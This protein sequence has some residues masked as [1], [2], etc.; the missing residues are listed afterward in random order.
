ML[1]GMDISSLFSFLHGPYFLFGKIRILEREVH[2]TLME[3]DLFLVD[4]NGMF[5]HNSH[6]KSQHIYIWVYVNLDHGCMKR[7][8]TRVTTI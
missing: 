2:G 5:L 7:I 4:K 1:F 8:S 6:C 3:F